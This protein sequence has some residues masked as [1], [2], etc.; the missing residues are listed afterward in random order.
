AITYTAALGASEKSE[1]TITMALL[2]E[3]IDAG[4]DEWKP[5]DIDY[6]HYFQAGSPVDCLKHA[7]LV[8]ALMQMVADPEPFQYMDTHAGTGVYDLSSPEALRF[9]NHVTGIQRLAESQSHRSR[10]MAEYVKIH[11]RFGSENDY[12]GSPA[13]ASCFLRPQ[14]TALV[15]EASPKVGDALAEN[16]RRLER[17]AGAGCGTRVVRGDC[18][19]WF[20]RG[21]FEDGAR[22]LVLIDP[23]YDSASSS[24]KWNLFLVKVIRSRW[25]SSSVL[26]WYPCISESQTDRF[27]QRLLA[28]G[29]GRILVAELEVAT[30]R[31]GPPTTSRRGAMGCEKPSRGP[32]VSV[33]LGGFCQG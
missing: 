7:V 12:L 23:P 16:L 21:G 6:V 10:G 14:D 31:V 5:D 4:L 33:S 17:G 20:A 24:D 1:W 30:T 22:K 15:F 28:M 26:L 29:L 8:E 11:R 18:Y 3:V 32:G 2:Q 27:Q 25:P 13:I 19:K 9:G